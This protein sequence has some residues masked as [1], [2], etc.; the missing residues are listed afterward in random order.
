VFL[1]DREKLPVPSFAKRYI[2]KTVIGRML[3]ECGL[4]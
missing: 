4:I 2:E 3:E 1:R